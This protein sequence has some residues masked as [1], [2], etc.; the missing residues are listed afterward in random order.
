MDDNA[1]L[2]LPVTLKVVNGTNCSCGNCDKGCNTFC[3]SNSAQYM[4]ENCGDEIY[5]TF[6]QSNISELRS[7][8]DK[9]IINSFIIWLSTLHG[10]VVSI[11]LSVLNAIN[12]HIE[13][14]L[15]ANCHEYEMSFTLK[16]EE[17][18]CNPSYR[19]TKCVLSELF[20]WVRCQ[21]YNN[22]MYTTSLPLLAHAEF[23]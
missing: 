14:F 6:T 20:S 15:L 1:I 9:M 19:L 2:Y 10:N 13:S 21:S 23:T 4:W 22:N 8:Y 18:N 12:I 17:L 7:K 11:I 16:I 5:M 3:P